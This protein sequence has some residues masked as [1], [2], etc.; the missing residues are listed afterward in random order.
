MIKHL[1]HRA[2]HFGPE[3]KLEILR[4]RV[5]LRHN[6]F[7]IDIRMKQFYQGLRWRPLPK[8]VIGAARRRVNEHWRP[9]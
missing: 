2:V 7:K 9:A 3:T 6:R 4:W 8:R 5:G 1:Y